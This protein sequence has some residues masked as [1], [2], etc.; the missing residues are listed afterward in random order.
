MDSMPSSESF[1]IQVPM[2]MRPT[3]INQVFAETRGPRLWLGLKPEKEL[4]PCALCLPWKSR[5]IERAESSRV[6]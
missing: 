5:R 4:G 6:S 1:R 2:S 3:V